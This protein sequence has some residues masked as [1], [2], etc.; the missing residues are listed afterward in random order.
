M[1]LLIGLV[2]AIRTARAE[3]AVKPGRRIA[4]R[5]AAGD[6]RAFLE[7]QRRLFAGLARL[8]PARLEIGGRLVAPD[9]HAVMLAVGDIEVYLS[10]AGVVVP[11][12]EG[13]R[14]RKELAQVK[15]QKA[16][17]QALLANKEF[18]AKAPPPVVAREQSKLTDLRARAARL[19]ERVEGL[20]QRCYGLGEPGG[21]ELAS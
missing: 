5:V 12:V 18:L 6:R 13:R 20:A 4:A 14:L 1:G 10:L 11:G 21:Q 9:G 16:R 15:V 3:H 2:R 8:D 7:A 19:E 17:C